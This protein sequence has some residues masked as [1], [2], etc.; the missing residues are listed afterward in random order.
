MSDH[1]EKSGADPMNKHPDWVTVGISIV[2]IATIVAAATTA[3]AIGIVL[4]TTNDDALP[5]TWLAVGAA[6]ASL[7]AYYTVVMTGLSTLFRAAL[8]DREKEAKRSAIALNLQ[9]FA[10]LVFAAV[11]IVGPL[12]TSAGP[13]ADAN[14]EQPLCSGYD[15]S[16]SGDRSRCGITVIDGDNRPAS[17]ATGLDPEPTATALPNQTAAPTPACYA[18]ASADANTETCIQYGGQVLRGALL[19]P[20]ASMPNC[21]PSPPS[22]VC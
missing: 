17:V 13:G 21:A 2:T 14:G 7:A 18:H 15:R 11:A 1:S 19:L 16:A 12:L 9:I 20:I 6:L 5:I 3:A 10:A 22:P 4:E 8:P